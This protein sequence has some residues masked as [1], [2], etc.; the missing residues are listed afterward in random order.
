MKL[1]KST[2]KNSF[3]DMFL[4]TEE[5]YYV[6]LENAAD[7]LSRPPVLVLTDDDAVKTHKNPRVREYNIK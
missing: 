1:I 4:L 5:H 6:A 7:K 3:V 2:I